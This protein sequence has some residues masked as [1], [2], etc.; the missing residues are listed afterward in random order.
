MTSTRRQKLK[1]SRPTIFISIHHK[2]QRERQ[3]TILN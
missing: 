3:N 1:E 2:W